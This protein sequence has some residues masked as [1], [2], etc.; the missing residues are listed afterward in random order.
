[1]TEL[2]R[3]VQYSL[4]M[5]TTLKCRAPRCA[6]ATV[7]IVFCCGNALNEMLQLTF[8]PVYKATSMAFGVDDFA[9]SMLP[10]S[11]LITFL[12][13]TLM[14]SR[15]RLGLRNSLLGGAAVQCLGTWLRF[16]ACAIPVQGPPPPG[17]F[18]LLMTGQVLGAL[19]QPVFTNFPAVLST[20]WFAAGDRSLATVAATLSNPIG[21]ALGSAV[22]G[23]IVPD[24]VDSDT[25]RLYLGH[26]T[27][28][29]T[30]VATLVAA[31][32]YF[33]VPEAPESP[34]SV[35]VALR[36]Q[37]L[38][39]HSD[40]AAV[41]AA[42]DGAKSR[43]R[44]SQD[45]VPLLDN[46]S[47][48]TS[49]IITDSQKDA[50]QSASPRS[51][52]SGS[53]WAALMHEYHSLLFHHPNFLRLLIGFGL[54]VG[55]F[56]ALLSLLGQVLDPCGYS[57]QTAG[58]AGGIMLASG[59][60]TSAA[61]GFVLRAT[62][63]FVPVLR[64]GIGIAILAL[65]G[66]LAC[67]RPSQEALLLA[68]CAI[69]GASAV[70]LFPVTLE[71]AAE[72]TFPMAEDVSGG[73]LTMAGKGVGALLVLAMQPLISRSD[74]SSVATPFAALL[75]SVLL[76]STVSFFM[77]KRDYRRGDA[78]RRAAVSSSREPQ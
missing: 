72:C 78:E 15:L 63:A 27:L 31:G 33:L 61:A 24:D 2:H 47:G 30:I 75:L 6:A 71:S 69:L 29:Q 65:I 7:L 1:M 42:D 76:A 58:L 36:S 67:L 16:A 70:P 55:A 5:V 28:V 54:G 14:V 10:L 34:S 51:G 37:L 32:V 52:S 74:C 26:I 18:A 25:A 57:A 8:T 44:V 3:T 23:F 19:A 12:P 13:A 48:G 53:S 50:A 62:G 39:L 59:L 35:A 11:Y 4:S 43:R 77:F 49:T 46:S 22:P 56:N 66:F 40:A 68:A 73:L 21:N 60:F 41:A 9:T 38:L 20:L 17:L 64:S 45:A